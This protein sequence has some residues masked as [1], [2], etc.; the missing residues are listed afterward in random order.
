MLAPLFLAAAMMTNPAIDPPRTTSFV[1]FDRRASQG[2]PLTVVFFGASLTWGANATDPNVTSYRGLVAEGLRQHYPWTPFRF[3]DAAIGGTN[4][5]LGVIRFQR[6]VLRHQPDLVFLDF[7][8]ND[9]LLWADPEKLASYEA[10]V[11][12]IVLDA[13]CPLVM[14]ILPF[15]EHVDK[16]ELDKL[17]RRT[18][19]LRIAQAYGVPVGDAVVTVRNAVAAGADPARLWP[20]EAVHPCD[21]GYKLY[22]DAAWDALQ[23]AIAQDMTCTAPAKMLHGETYM[24]AARVRLSSLTPLPDGWTVAKPHV[25]AAFFDALMSRWLDDVTVAARPVEGDAVAPLQVAFRGSMV[26]LYGEKTVRSGKFLAFIDGQPVMTRGD[27]PQPRRFDAS[28]ARFGG[29]HHLVEILA[30]GLDPNIEHTLRIEPVFD[31]DQAHELRIESIGVAGPRA[32]V[33]LP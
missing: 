22:A 31:H 12:R 33:W 2:Q 28:S 20:F 24:T 8:A 11:R 23:L 17:R 27:Q 10:L 29:N 16:H 15:R 6:D 5:Q 1:D 32:A 9:D 26:M 30:T 25:Q 21:D 3:V 19:H 13:Q 18:A 14:M 4:S 7:T